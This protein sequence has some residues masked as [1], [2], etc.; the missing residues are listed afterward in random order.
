MYPLL[1]PLL[2]ALD[3]ETAHDLTF[4]GLDAAARFGLARTFAPEVPA[5]PV[6]A[7]GLSFPNRVGLAAG[8]DKNAAHV[9][10][11]AALGFGFLECGTVTPRAQPGNPRPRLFRLPE[12]EA[13]IN[14][15]GFNNDGVERFLGN[16]ER[17]SWTGILGLNIGKNFDTP[18]ARA[19]DDYVS[20]LRAVHARASYVTVNVSSPNTKGLRELQADDTLA[21]LLS[22][23]KTEQARL[24]DAQGKYTPL[25]VKIAP[26]LAP[27]AV[28]GIARLL[29]RH[30]VDGV[31]ATNTTVARDKVEGLRHSDE[32]GGLS[33]GPLRE[34]AT[35]VIRTLAKALDGALPIIGV[36]G[37]LSGADAK[38]KIDAGAT[39]VQLYTGLIYRGP[40]LVAECARALAGA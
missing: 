3:P 11:L 17:A 26:D 27:S 23:L 21:P 32:E 38:E 1:R 10:A 12:A 18:N 4:A 22:A 7:M 19:I 24:A 5:S 36:G 16:L 8:L 37:I 2:F 40:G 31:V 25:A 28:A 29:V 30:Q 35:Q 13:L 9:D 33:G 6:T 15:M 39:L 20:C 34:R 14:R